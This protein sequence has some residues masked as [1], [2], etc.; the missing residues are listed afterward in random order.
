MGGK[1]RTAKNGVHR[2]VR[3]MK[4]RYWVAVIPTSY[5]LRYCLPSLL[6][7]VFIQI[8]YYSGSLFDDFFCT[9]TRF[10]CWPA[11]G[12]P[13]LSA[14]INWLSAQQ[15][16]PPR[17]ILLLLTVL[18]FKPFTSNSKGWSRL[19]CRNRRTDSISSNQT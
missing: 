16:R 3:S 2:A 6:R 4:V 8:Q 9:A 7:E 12:V 18:D 17:L 1:L 19:A 11:F 13:S 5:L 14:V 15:L 10:S